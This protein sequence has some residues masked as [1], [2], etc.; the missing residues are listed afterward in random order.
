MSIDRLDPAAAK[1]RLDET[2]DAVYLDVRTPDEFAAGHPTGAYNIPIVEFTPAGPQPNRVF[3]DVVEAHFEKNR[4]LVVGCQVG[5]RSMMAC[6]VLASL[7]FT[8]LVNVEGGYG[9]AKEPMTGQVMIEGWAA[10]DYPISTTP[11]SGRSWSE[12]SQAAPE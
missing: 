6:E 10:R 9:G 12:L 7:G 8:R 11:E 1:S 4:T 5:Q 3:A 2:D